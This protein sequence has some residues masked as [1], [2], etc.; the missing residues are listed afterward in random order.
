M[1][2]IRG[3]Q[4]GVVYQTEAGPSTLLCANGSRNESEV[5]VDPRELVIDRAV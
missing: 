1:A 4:P 2:G 5:V 3:R